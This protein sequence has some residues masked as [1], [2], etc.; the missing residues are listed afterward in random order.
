MC[1]FCRTVHT[2]EPLPARLKRK[3]SARMKL[4]TVDEKG[5]FVQFKE[6]NF[7]DDNREID[8]ED[9]LEKNPD[10]FFSENKILII[11]RQVITNLNTSIDLLGVDNHGNTIV[12]ELKRNKTP[13]ETLAQLLEY[14]S[15][16]D[17]IDYEQL[18]E[19]FQQYSGDE[20]NLEDYH[21]EYFYDN[22]DVQNISW[23]KS[24]KLLIVAQEI[25]PDIRQTSLFLRKKGLEVS[26]AEFK[27]F[28]DSSGNR[29][30]SS[31]FIVGEE[32]YIKQ[33][34]KSAP[35]QKTDIDTFLK[36]IDKYGK[37]VFTKIFEL[38]DNNDI[39]LRWGAK[40]FSFNVSVDGEL[41]GVFFGYPPNCPY[42]QSIIT[43]FKQIEK[44]VKDSD[45]IL[46]FYKNEIAKLNIFNKKV[47]YLGTNELKWMIDNQVNSNTIDKFIDIITEISNRIKKKY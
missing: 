21:S 17:N 26:C 35:S 41:I 22:E 7:H 42:K 16:I 4:Y 11:G 43:G 15:Y 37:P 33:Q 34:P 36:S 27:Y 14:A 6:E 23:N 8:L 13:R 2:A 38:V 3:K 32:N 1:G 31:D 45:D 10:Y 29:I 40:G 25:T 47:G 12:I 46:D 19:I 44:K 9:L 5:R 28:T 18:N 39:I 24:M 20:A 30:I